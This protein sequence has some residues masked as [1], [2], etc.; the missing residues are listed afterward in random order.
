MT[1]RTFGRDLTPQP[2]DILLMQIGGWT[3]KLV[4]VLQALNGDLSPWTHAAV[5]LDDGELFEAKPSGGGVIKLH[6][7]RNR[8]MAIVDHVKRGAAYEP[9]KLAD[10][11]RADIVKTARGFTGVGYSWGTYLYLAAYR[12]GIRPGW[13]KRRV[14]DSRRMICSQAA[15]RAYADAGVA[16]FDDGRMPCDVT[17]GDLGKLL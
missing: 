17:P 16:L 8:R 3:G 5:M 11:Q 12:L 1:T 7:Y 13:L 14:Q 6:A 9:L 10:S 4:W 15:D 2:G